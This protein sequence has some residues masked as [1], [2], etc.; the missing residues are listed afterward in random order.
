MDVIECNYC[1]G[2]RHYG[3][4]NFPC[5]L[6]YDLKKEIDKLKKKGKYKE[7]MELL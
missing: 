6:C 7:A 3:C 2:I 5:Y 1:E 4:P